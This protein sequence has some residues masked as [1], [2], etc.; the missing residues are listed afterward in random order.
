MN[1]FKK[2]ILCADDFGLSSQVSKGILKLV[3]MGRLSAVSCMVNTLNFPL[4]AKELV[5]VADKTLVGLHFN[6]TE[7]LFLANKNKA[8][9]GLAELLIRT[10][11]GLVSSSLIKAELSAQLAQFTQVFGR[12]P[13]FIDGH[14]HVHQFP[15][16]REQLLRL[17]RSS[18]NPSEVFVRSTYPNI[19]PPYPVKNA[20]L[21]CTGG[22][23]LKKKLIQ[24]NIAH[25][26]CFA[27]VYDFSAD[28][29]Y[30]S[31]FRGWLKK[32]EEGTLIMCHPAIGVQ[33]DDPIAKA[34]VMEMSYFA[35]EQFL[36]DCVR[37]KVHIQLPNLG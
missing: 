17:H 6:L 24:A 26:T 31:L 27:G 3:G 14:Q 9:F 7:G 30:S 11:L 1:E 28:V 35:S 22:R 15:V 23:S 13:D 21:S 37:F 2:I 29:D 25:N 4:F 5:S 20:I 19:S 10:H 12:R 32:V 33:Q 34:R 16:I 8:G 18:F 36:E